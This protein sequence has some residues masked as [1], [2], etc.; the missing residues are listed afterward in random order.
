MGG[1]FL[2]PPFN[3]DMKRSTDAAYGEELAR[4]IAGQMAVARKIRTLV[5]KR[6][7][8]CLKMLP[9][10]ERPLTQESGDVWSLPHQSALQPRR[11]CESMLPDS[12]S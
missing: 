4:S 12:R 1:L 5:Q 9:E 2:P 3:C 8:T 7:S 6:P 10:D 11:P